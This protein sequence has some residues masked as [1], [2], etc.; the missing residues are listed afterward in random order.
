MTSLNQVNCEVCEASRLFNQG[1]WKKNSFWVT[2]SILLLFGVMIMSMIAVKA[3]L[4]ITSL[5][6]SGQIIIID[7]GHGGADGGAVSKD[8]LVEKEITLKIAKFL[9]DYLQEGGAYVIMTRE[10]DED[11]A[12]PNTEK[13]S[14]RKAED[15]MKRVHLIK[16]KQAD[17]V[18][19]IHLN[20]FPQSRYSGA[21]TFYH[22]S[23]QENK[24]LASFIQQSL[25]EQLKNT[26]RVPKQKGDVYLLKESPVPTA[27]V[28]V[29]FLSN[30]EETAL[31]RD[32][33]YQKKLAASIYYGIIGFYTDQQEPNF[34]S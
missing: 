13:L 31:L 28:E 7:P 30:P 23:R 2:A 10:E 19:S 4:Q 20:A 3:N 9:R 11:L 18:V 25:I 14:K 27:L 29:G 17:A 15:L 1:F 21:Q 34:E 22:P 24:R 32:E 8:G 6:L 5:P 16:I 12:D 26:D 33:G